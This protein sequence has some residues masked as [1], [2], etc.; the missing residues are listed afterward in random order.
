MMSDA[1]VPVIPLKSAPGERTSWNRSKGTVYLWAVAELLF[2]TNPWQ[3]S[4]SLRAKVLR[5][6]GAEIGVRVIMR[7]RMRVR[8]PWKLHIGDDCWIGEGVWFHN[9]DHIRVENDV[10]ISQEAFLTTGSHAHRTDM[11]LITRP[12]E[13]GAG[14]WITSRCMVLGGTRLGESCLVKPMSLVSGTSPANS[15]LEG[16]P[17]RVTG[18]RFGDR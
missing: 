10:V 3:I 17:A 6:F 13:I 11:A 12:I 18:V 14:T 2:V 4:S 8:F 16:N 7:P 5:L 1:R 15:V 9:Q